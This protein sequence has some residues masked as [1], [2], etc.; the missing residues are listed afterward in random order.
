MDQGYNPLNRS[1][2]PILPDLDEQR[3]S[4]VMFAAV[5]PTLYLGFLPDHVFWSLYLP[6]GPTSM[7]IRGGLLTH[8][9]AR[10]LPAYDRLVEWVGEGQAGLFAQDAG[11]N[12]SVQLG[13]ASRYARRGPYAREEATLPQWNSWIA[14]RYRSAYKDL[15]A[16]E[17]NQSRLVPL[18]EQPRS[19]RD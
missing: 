15:L 9:S 18:D 14:Q 6:E 13:R 3:R 5:P 2:L 16:R 12:T 17:L 4:Q 8:A 7:R 19:L 11:A 10:D 1:L